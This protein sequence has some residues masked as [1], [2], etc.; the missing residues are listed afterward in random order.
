MLTKSDILHIELSGD[1]VQ[2]SKV[3]A[4]SVV[5][6]QTLE[7]HYAEIKF[8]TIPD[9]MFI[10][11]LPKSFVVSY[12]LFSNEFLYVYVSAVSAFSDLFY[13]SDLMLRNPTSTHPRTQMFSNR[14]AS[15]G[16][17]NFEVRF[18]RQSVLYF[19]KMQIEF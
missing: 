17:W 11:F 13:L 1:R 5:R 6:T 18:E 4:S 7:L 3:C 9:I 19:E 15:T 10:I 8:L 12:T 16:T 14:E 2:V